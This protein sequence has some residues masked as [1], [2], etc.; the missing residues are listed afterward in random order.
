[1]AKPVLN[2]GRPKPGFCFYHSRKTSFS[3]KRFSINY[4]LIIFYYLKEYCISFYNILH[5][6][7]YFPY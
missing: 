5:S 1:M 3:N 4:K 7:L 6:F 2:H